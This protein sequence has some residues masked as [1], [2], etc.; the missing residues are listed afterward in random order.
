MLFSFCCYLTAGKLGV[1]LSGIILQFL[2]LLC[3]NLGFRHLKQSNSLSL[4]LFFS[5]LLVGYNSVCFYDSQHCPKPPHMAH[6]YIVCFLFTLLL[7]LVIEALVANFSFFLK[8]RAFWTRVPNFVFKCD[9]LK[10]EAYG[11]VGGNVRS[12]RKSCA[13]PRGS[14]LNTTLVVMTLARRG[15]L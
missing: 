12:L 14:L 8:S 3:P 10:L 7:L 1:H 15:S 6:I 13:K 4:S 5:S 11:K 9:Y 2:K